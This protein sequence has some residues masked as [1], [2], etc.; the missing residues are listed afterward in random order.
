MKPQQLARLLDVNPATIR[1]WSEQF[2]EFLSPNAAGGGGAHRAYSE[3]DSRIMAWIAVMKAQNV[4]FSDIKTT[5]KAAQA[6]YWHNLPPMPG[7]IVGDEPI[8]V[9]PREA[10]EERVR[11]LEERFRLQ[12]SSLEKERDQLQTRLDQSEAEKA[13]L[14][15]QLMQVTERLLT[16]NDRLTIL[17]ERESKRRK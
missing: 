11:A 10:V 17:L 16:L 7:S 9:V 6:N 1:K 12:V 15:R 14:R 8:A 3:Q 2:T 13:E 4:S 5:L